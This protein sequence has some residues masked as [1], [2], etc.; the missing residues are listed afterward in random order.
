MDAAQIIL[1]LV[2]IILTILLVALGI[3]V[4]F[5]LRELK[6]AVGK[7]NKILEDTGVI[8]ESVSTPLATLSS[9]M[10][11]IKTGISAANLLKK[12][13]KFGEKKNEGTEVSELKSDH[14]ISEEK[15]PLIRRF[16]KG[17]SR[18]RNL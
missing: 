14:A 10:M 1:F 11:G 18:K 16:F 6:R 13:S 15:K 5:I 9:L 17:I 12:V 4:F 3:Q 8:T 7:A 2:I